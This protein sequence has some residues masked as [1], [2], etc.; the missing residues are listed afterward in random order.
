[1]GTYMVVSGVVAAHPSPSH[2]HVA[3]HTS[4]DEQNLFFQIFIF[5]FFIRTGYKVYT[6]IQTLY[7]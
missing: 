6:H 2:A 1:M 5:D 7:L 4:A 3:D